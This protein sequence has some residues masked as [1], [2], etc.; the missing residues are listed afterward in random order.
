M[1]AEQVVTIRIGKA[2]KKYRRLREGD[3]IEEG[4]VLAQLD[5]RLARNDLAVQRA[6][7]SA[8][9]ADLEAVPNERMLSEIAH[10]AKVIVRTGAFNPWGN[11][12]MI[13]GTV[14]DEWFQISGT[15]MPELYRQRRDRMK[16]P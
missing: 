9:G 11:V 7:L 13:C 14:P 2:E 12:A 15:V 16:K 1:P 10:S 5:D 4:E 8:A 6:K 3:R